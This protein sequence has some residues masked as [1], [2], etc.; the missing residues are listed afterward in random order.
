LA[1]NFRTHTELIQQQPWIQGYC[2]TQLYDTFQ[3]Q[4]GLL[5]AHR[6]LKVN[7]DVIKKTNQEKHGVA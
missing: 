7:L 5:D 3:E 2:F 4:N 1:E 6:K